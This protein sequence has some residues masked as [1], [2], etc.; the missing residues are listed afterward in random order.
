MARVDIAVTG[1]WSSLWSL[2][3]QHKQIFPAFPRHKQR[4][5]FARY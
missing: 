2:L 5:A 3:Y 1:D 4:V